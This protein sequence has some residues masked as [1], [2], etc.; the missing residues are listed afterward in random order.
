MRQ[1]LIS[2]LF[3]AAMLAAPSVTLADAGH[4]KPKAV[5][6]THMAEMGGHH[7]TDSHH[8]EHSETFRSGRPGKVEEVDRVIHVTAS[9]K[10][11]FDPPDFRVRPGETIRFVVKNEG[12]IDHEFVVGTRDEH[13]EHRKEM[14]EQ[15]GMGPMEH[16]DPNAITVPPGQTR[17]LI[18]TFSEAEDI[19]AA[20]NLPGHYEA[21]MHVAIEVSGSPLA[22]K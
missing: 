7:D 12:R 21:G 14:R 16:E 8:D 9:D 1:P 10:M 17:E 22:Q 20:C 15:M 5:D 11:R 4:G 2:V 6:D 19:Q 13:Q 3:T 18:W